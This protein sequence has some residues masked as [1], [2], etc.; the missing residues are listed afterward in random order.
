MYHI[1]SN[2]EIEM[3]N[4]ILTRYKSN[5]NSIGREMFF[6]FSMRKSRLQNSIDKY[7][8]INKYCPFAA[9]YIAQKN[10]KKIK[11]PNTELYTCV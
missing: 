2:I 9:F 6:F 1:V 8:Y 10:L 4:P 3:N 5:L 11:S 7:I